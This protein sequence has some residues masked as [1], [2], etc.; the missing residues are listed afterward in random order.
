M[1]VHAAPAF[2]HVVRWAQA[3]PQ[4]HVGHLARVARIEAL[5]KRHPGLFLGG[6]SFRGVALNDCVEQAEALALRLTATFGGASI[7]D[8]RPS[9]G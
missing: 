5:A 4:Y 2:Q 1:R 7:S 8:P 3:I 9:T 6:N